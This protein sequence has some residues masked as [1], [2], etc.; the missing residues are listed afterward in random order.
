M[1]DK[2]KWK[3]GKFEACEEGA[4]Y[5]PNGSNCFNLHGNEYI[6]IPY[7]PF[8]GTNILMPE[9][10]EPLIVK[11]GE[12][13]V[14]YDKGKDFLCV[15][16]ELNGNMPCFISGQSGF[17]KDSGWK[18][19]TGPNRDITELTDEIAK[20]RPMVMCGDDKD[21][22]CKLYGITED[23]RIISLNKYNCIVP[24]RTVSLA[25]AH[26]LQESE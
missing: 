16:K 26:E 10:A 25:T 14:A 7:C 5:F 15:T 13:W 21:I 12:T 18:S 24:W 8:C 20:W 4:E 22:I 1:G 17:T 9:P 11:S 6:G 19:F 23:R 2:C 3:D